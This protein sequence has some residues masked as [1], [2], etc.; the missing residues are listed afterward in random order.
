MKRLL[1]AVFIIALI[2]GAAWA[3]K[4][5]AAWAIKRQIVQATGATV[6]VWNDFAWNPF[7]HL[8]MSDIQI[9]AS[10]SFD[11]RIQTLDVRY[12]MLDV[13]RFKKIKR[14]T[15]DGLSVVVEQAK[16][17]NGGSGWDGR[18]DQWHLFADDIFLSRV[19]ARF[20]AANF[21]VKN[22]SVKLHLGHG[23]IAADAI[24][25]GKMSI[26][27][28]RG[29][30]HMTHDQLTVGPLTGDVLGGAVEAEL[31]VPLAV[32]PVIDARLNIVGLDLDALTDTFELKK[33]VQAHGKLSGALV[34]T[35]EGLKLKS[36]NGTVSSLQGGAVSIQ[37]TRF[38]K[39]LAAYSKQPEDI[40]VESLKDY[41]YNTG[42]IK[43]WIEDGGLVLGIRMDGEQGKRDLQVKLHD[44]ISP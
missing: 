11:L 13:V 23:P 16:K 19:D 29:N 22:A 24:Q 31:R 10:N 33:K 25:V 20:K 15:V 39:N 30:A 3:F 42:G 18:T 12:S 9:R 14:L 27:I 40:V 43:I 36:I 41:Q 28:V 1:I 32:D 8:R 35:F 17:G 5:A 2:A 38:L 37:D 21:T 26:D 6:V 44:F 7:N 4:P 34:M